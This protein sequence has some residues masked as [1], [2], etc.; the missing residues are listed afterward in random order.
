MSDRGRIAPV[1][2]AM[3]VGALA[4]LAFS[5]VPLLFDAEWLAW[6]LVPAFAVVGGILAFMYLSS[7][8]SDAGSK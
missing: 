8:E 7:R 3:C 1:T 2:L 6:L 5:P 4:A